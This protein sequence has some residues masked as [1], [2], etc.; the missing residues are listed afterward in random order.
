MYYL[1]PQLYLYINIYMLY[2]FGHIILWFCSFNEV[3]ASRAFI[4]CV[5]TYYYYN[6]YYTRYKK[7]RSS[8]LVCGNI[9][10]CNL[11]VLERNMQINKEPLVA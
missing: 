10:K 8:F 1:L 3:T 5:T 4:F 11:I 2:F 6:N 7:T 9:S